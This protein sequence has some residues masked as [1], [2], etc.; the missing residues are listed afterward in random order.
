[1]DANDFFNN[2]AGRAKPEFKQNQF[3]GT[4]GGPIRKNKTFFFGDYQGTRVRAARTNIV[5][6]PAPAE[7]NG[8]FSGILGDQVGTDALGRPV[9][10]NEIFNPATTRTVNG[11]VVRDGFGFDAATGMPIPGQANIIPSAQLDPIAHNIAALYPAPT[12][13]GSLANNYIVNAPGRD[14]I[15][16]MDVR[17]DHYLSDRQQLFGRFSLSQRTRFQAP[18]L[19]PNSAE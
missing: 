7:I 5:T 19:R 4:L 14:T 11:S 6:V 10:A 17:G 8:D 13:A 3:G 12:V 15:D 2:R 16:Q 9:F 1:M 18:P